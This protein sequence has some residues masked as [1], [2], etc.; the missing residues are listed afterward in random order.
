MIA[1]AC[2]LAWKIIFLDTKL[3]FT[4]YIVVRVL[5]NNRD[6]HYR[7]II[8]CI[9]VAFFNAVLRL[10]PESHLSLYRL[11]MPLQMCIIFIWSKACFKK[12]V[13]FSLALCVTNVFSLY[14]GGYNLD[15]SIVPVFTVHYLTIAMFYLTVD[16]IYKKGLGNDFIS[17]LNSLDESD[18]N[19][20]LRQ[21][22][23]ARQQVRKNYR[24]L[25]KKWEYDYWDNIQNECLEAHKKKDIG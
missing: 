16:I 19:V 11:L 3:T 20:Q 10:S 24:K 25:R 17:F 12:M 6:F 8:F 15:L 13:F 2:F 1:K 22:I 5:F 7:I 21:A 23:E 14:L 9:F 18:L 4:E